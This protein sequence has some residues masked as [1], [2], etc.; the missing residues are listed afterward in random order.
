MFPF[1]ANSH[2]SVTCFIY[3]EEEQSYFHSKRRSALKA[4]A[5]RNGYGYIP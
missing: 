5:G 2:S 4:I 3:I 1:Q